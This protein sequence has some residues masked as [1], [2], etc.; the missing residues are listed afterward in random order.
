MPTLR[1]KQKL[2]KLNYLDSNLG[3]TCCECRESLSL[4]SWLKYVDTVSTLGLRPDLVLL[5]SASSTACEEDELF[6]IL[7]PKIQPNNNV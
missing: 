2:F 1:N 7:F 5:E 6:V 3:I 4:L